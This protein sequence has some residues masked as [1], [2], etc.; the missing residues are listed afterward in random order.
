D[1]APQVWS[2]F[3]CMRREHRL[4]V[5]SR[6]VAQDGVRSLKELFRPE[7]KRH[8]LD[9]AAGFNNLRRHGVQM[10]DYLR[11]CTP[12]EE[13]SQ[14]SDRRRIRPGCLGKGWFDGY[15]LKHDCGVGHGAPEYTD[16]VERGREWMNAFEADPP[17]SRFEAHDAAV[18]SRA[19][20]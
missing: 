19:E 16:M 8:L 10:G 20:D 14:E 18:G 13:A 11:A 12:A 3:V 15:C 2:V 9:P 1:Q 17:P 7:R 5:G 4:V 6:F